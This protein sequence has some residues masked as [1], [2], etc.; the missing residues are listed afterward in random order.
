MRHFMNLHMKS[1]I[2]AALLVSLLLCSL[3]CNEGNLDVEPTGLTEDG[4]FVEE[5]EFERAILGVYAKLS[6]FYWYNG[7]QFNFV[8]AS[9]ILPGDD[10]TSAGEDEFE[11]FGN[12]NPGSGRLTYF[13]V[14]IY[15]M[16]ARA[17]VV[18]EKIDNVA[19]GVY[20]TPGL[21]ESNKGEA[22][23][24]RGYAHY[25]LWNLFGTAPVRA[26]RVTLL[27]QSK[28]A[29]STGTQLLDQAISDFGAAAE[30]LPQTWD[31]DNRGRLTRN[32]ANGMLGKALVFRGT[33]N[34]ADADYQAAITAFNKIT[35]AMLVP[36]FD[37][38]FAFDTENNEESLFEF[39]AT[40]AFATDNVWLPNDFD[41]AVG[42]LS[43]YWGFYDNHWT[44]FGKQPFIATQKLIDIYEDGDPRR[45]L[46]IDMDTKAF[47][48]YVARDK[49][50][51]S[52]AASV[53][54]PRVLRYADVLL[55]KAE[56]LNESGGST[57]EAI[58]LINE[59]RTRA[60]GAEAAP[61]NRDNTVTDRATIRQW[62]MDERFMELAG[63][64]QRW[65]D[66]R[67][68]SLGGQIT[69]DNA[70]F[71]SA[72]PGSMGFIATRHINFPIPTAETNVNPNVTQNAGY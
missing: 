62:I 65:F 11:I 67:R 55:L 31:D 64:A 56:A 53:N 30:L 45:D 6:D 34:D 20:L 10:I 44:M 15:Q 1:K 5:I 47:R 19:E 25:L 46:T 59:V 58:D 27:E 16:I 68:W 37:D 18:I 7:G 39:Q 60:R 36:Q 24:L 48:K 63:E 12:I 69:L 23:F 17:N 49:L 70:F 43:A 42:S 29:S 35:G 9:T 33:V 50:T 66:L 41:N 54:N 61:A 38:N 51:N 3:S 71:D 21:R 72:I 13:Y 32:A 2:S 40:Q 14:A 4:Y 8:Q 28:P 57:T 26:E 52:G 22:L